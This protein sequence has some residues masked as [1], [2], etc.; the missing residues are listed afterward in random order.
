MSFAA[1]EARV[2]ASVL[3]HLSNAQA[4]LDGFPVQGIFKRDYV[5]AGGGMGMSSTAPT[6]RM[7]S[8]DVPINPV[9]KLLIVNGVTYR[10]AAHEPDG[11]GVSPAPIAD[12][13][14]YFRVAI[15]GS[16]GLSVLLLE[17]TL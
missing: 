11:T 4:T 8:F 14:Q 5:E 15:P 16:T 1:L 12:L 6:F 17:C 10:V 7:S 9:G 13:D 2:N 3:K